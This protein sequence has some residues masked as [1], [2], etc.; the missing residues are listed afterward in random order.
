MLNIERTKRKGESAQERIE[1]GPAKEDEILKEITK[2][3][4]KGSKELGRD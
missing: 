3:K 4:G 1:F 2:Q